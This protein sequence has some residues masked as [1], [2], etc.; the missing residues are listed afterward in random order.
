MT[1]QGPIPGSIF[2]DASIA[3]ALLLEE[4]AA[5]V[6]RRRLDEWSAAAVDLVVPAAF[7]WE[8]V[9]PLARR[10]AYS[11]ENV[12][13]AVHEVDLLEFRTIE[14][15]RVQLLA[16]IDLVERFGLTAFDAQYLALADQLDGGLA[17]LDA[18]LVSAAGARAMPILGDHRMHESVGVYEHDATW[19]RYKGASAYL[20]KLRADLNE[21]A[22][23]VNGR[24][25]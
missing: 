20:A 22:R 21:V 25:D 11:G 7:W 8:V 12:L 24:A 17:S 3:L 15:D 2:I 14:P 13:R 19:P 9:N 5:K 18:A 1:V 16:T 23:P 6:I 10:Y 4:P